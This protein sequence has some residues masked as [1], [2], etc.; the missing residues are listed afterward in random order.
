MTS[1]EFRTLALALPGA[2]E[3]GHMGH[4]DFRVGGRIFATLGPDGSWGMVKL[5][6]EQQASY[7]RT[8]SESFRP[9][10]GSWGRN[11]A[12]IVTLKSASESVTREALESAWRNVTAKRPGKKRS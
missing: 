9:A 11:G 4:P 2:T 7:L 6:A 3:V 1:E 8:A 5:T 10:S 12:T